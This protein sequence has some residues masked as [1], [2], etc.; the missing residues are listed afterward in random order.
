QLTSNELKQISQAITSDV[1]LRRLQNFKVSNDTGKLYNWTIECDGKIKATG[2]IMP[3][4]KGLLTVKNVEMGLVPIRLVITQH[5][6][7][8]NP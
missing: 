5:E 6:N 1:T 3:N 8:T 4:E 7:T 2:Q